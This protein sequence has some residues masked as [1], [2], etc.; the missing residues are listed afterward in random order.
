MEISRDSEGNEPHVVQGFTEDRPGHSSD[1]V[2]ECEREPNKR[3]DGTFHDDVYSAPLHTNKHSTTG[4][5]DLETRSPQWVPSGHPPY[6][7]AVTT[8]GRGVAQPHEHAHATQVTDRSVEHGWRP[9]K[10]GSGAKVR[11]TEA[12][13]HVDRR[14]CGTESGL[15][16]W[17]VPNSW[18]SSWDVQGDLRQRAESAAGFSSAAR[19]HRQRRRSVFFHVLVVRLT[20]R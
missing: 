6:I 13:G 4:C 12:V 14:G 15:D 5:F 16:F 8:E 3:K 20:G 18:S 17:M 9:H 1:H 2:V 19:V 10:P 7:G 11:D